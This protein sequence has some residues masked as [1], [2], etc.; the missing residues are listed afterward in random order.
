MEAC[1]CVGVTVVY[2]C[3]IY[4]GKYTGDHTHSKWEY[5]TL[6]VRTFLYEQE[7]FLP[8]LS[9]C[10]FS[11]N[12]TY[13]IHKVIKLLRLRLINTRDHNGVMLRS[14]TVDKYLVYYQSKYSG[15]YYVSRSTSPIWGLTASMRKELITIYEAMQLRSTVRRLNY[16]IINCYKIVLVTERARTTTLKQLLGTFKP[17][18]SDHKLEHESYRTLCRP[19]LI[20]HYAILLV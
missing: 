20:I 6:L 14:I 4:A 8:L 18:L 10:W 15:H 9:V 5:T 19:A 12:Y 7:I 17:P 3:N 1:L 13:K 2:E 11:V 16:F